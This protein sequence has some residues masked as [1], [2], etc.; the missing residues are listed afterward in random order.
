M[1]NYNTN[2]Y[3]T[4]VYNT[5]NTYNMWK[6]RKCNYIDKLSNNNFITCDKKSSKYNGLCYSHQHI[7][8]FYKMEELRLEYITETMHHFIIEF[9]KAIDNDEEDENNNEC[10]INILK[11]MYLELCKN[12][13]IVQNKMKISLKK[14]LKYIID[15]VDD[16]HFGKLNLIML[17]L[18]SS[19]NDLALDELENKLN[20]FE[21]DVAS[22]GINSKSNICNIYI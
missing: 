11:N 19:N 14:K 6:L 5:D 1:N 3:D 12:Q 4:D 9:N 13:I 15:T 8:H 22:N 10:K 20:L 21:N 2:T 17:Y 7:T 16:K 18:F